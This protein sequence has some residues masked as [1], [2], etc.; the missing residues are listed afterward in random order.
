M[1]DKKF[2]LIMWSKKQKNK[3]LASLIKEYTDEDV[4]NVEREERIKKGRK[5]F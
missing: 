5:L 1:N 4:K 3:R 2:D